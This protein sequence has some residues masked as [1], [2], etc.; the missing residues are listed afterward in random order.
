MHGEHGFFIGPFMFGSDSEID[1][2]VLRFGHR[3]AFGIIPNKYFSVR[4]IRPV[5]VPEN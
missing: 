3:A 4:T 1:V 2:K 5:T